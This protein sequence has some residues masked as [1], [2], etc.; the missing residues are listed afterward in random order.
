[1]FQYNF[2][3]RTVPVS[4][5]VTVKWFRRFR[6]RVRFLGKRF[7]R[8]RFPVPVRFLGQ[9]SKLKTVSWWTFKIFFYFFCSGEGKGESRAT[10]RG[11]GR[12][13]IESSR[14]PGGG[15]PGA[16]EAWRGAGRVSA[17]NGGGGAIF[18]FF[19]AEMPAKK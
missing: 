11:G 1:M 16:G 14:R 9:S 18:F 6:F 5:P 4:V 12:F 19:R 7:R 2:T 8:F 10:G 15:L 17:G 3:E 13:F